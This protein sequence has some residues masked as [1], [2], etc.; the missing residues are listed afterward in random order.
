MARTHLVIPDSHATPSHNNDRFSLLGK[1]IIDRKPDVIVDIGDHADMPSLSSYDKGKKS[2]EGRRYKKDIA[3]V[4]ESLDFMF[5]PILEYNER[6][7]RNHKERYKPELHLT[8]G[9][10]E[11]R[12]NRV[13]ELHPELDGTLNTDDLGYAEYGFTVHPYTKPV[14]IDGIAYCHHFSSGVMGRPISGEHPAHAL[15][16]KMH[17]SCVQGHSHIRDFCERTGADGRRVQGLVVGCY[18]DE[19]QWEDYAGEANNMWWKGLI[20][21]HNVENGEFE[22]EFINVKQLRK[23]YG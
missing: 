6:Q 17:M 7:A 13:C 4:K 12:I 14:F 20:M 3:A 8:L 10:H 22:P 21:L 19:D 18:L 1:F 2:F 5:K 23:L 15:I 9:N 11:H 16:T